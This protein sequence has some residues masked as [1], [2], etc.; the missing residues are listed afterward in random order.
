MVNRLHL[1]L[2]SALFVAVWVA[3]SPPGLRAQTDPVEEAAQLVEEGTAQFQAR[4]FAEAAILFQRAYNLDP[5]PVLLFNL[6]RATQEMRDLPGA[7]GTFGRVMDTTDDPAIIQA[8]RDR[9]AQIDEELRGQGYDPETLTSADY[10]PRGTLVI[11]SEP[12]GAEVILQGS[13]LGT[14]PLRAGQINQGSYQMRLMLDGYHPIDTQVDI[15]GGGETNRSF[16]LQAR[17]ALEE[18]VPPEPGYLTVNSPQASMDV[19]ID[20]QRYSVT[21]LIRAPLAPGGYEVVISALGWEPYATRI[22]VQSG[23]TIVVN[24]QMAPVGGYR[25]TTTRSST[26]AGNGL[27]AAGGVLTATGAVFGIFALGSAARYNDRLS[28]PTRGT[29]RNQA[30]TQALISD[31]SIGTGAALLVT[32]LVL[33]L[34]QKDTDTL[35]RPDATRERLVFA[36]WADRQGR[37]GLRFGTRF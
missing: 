32:G 14:T 11:S 3:L 30:R 4:N 33:R 22:Q 17:T 13:S 24:A 16:T 7:R 8:C 34:V 21:P 28:D 12:A 1:R 2:L 36:P 6:A 35:P 18:Y 26:G 15:R 23:Q 9:I 10:V 25:T 29:L 5:H 20:G 31:I 27:L 19:Y 37:V